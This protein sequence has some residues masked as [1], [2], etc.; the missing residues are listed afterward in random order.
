MLLQCLQLPNAA[1]LLW[2]VCCGR[3]MPY[4]SA[5]VYAIQ[6]IGMAYDGIPIGFCISVRT[7]MYSFENAVARVHGQHACR[8][9]LSRHAEPS[10]AVP[11]H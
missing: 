2:A 11:R 5:S 10:N 4:L 1:Q 3:V 6:L 7:C 8:A 9:A